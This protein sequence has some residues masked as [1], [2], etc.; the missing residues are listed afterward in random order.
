MYCI[1]P[2]LTAFIYV[3]NIAST[4]NKYEPQRSCDKERRVLAVPRLFRY[5]GVN[6]VMKELVYSSTTHHHAEDPVYVWVTNSMKYC[7]S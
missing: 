3:E 6:N 7:V 2:L 4:C 5:E 1:L